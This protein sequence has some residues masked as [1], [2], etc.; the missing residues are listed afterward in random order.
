MNAPA[1]QKPGFGALWKNKM[2]TG[3]QPHYR[4]EVVLRDDYKAGET[5]RI[6]C[7]IKETRQGDKFLSLAENDK[8]YQK[9][10]EDVE[11]TSSYSARRKAS[12]DDDLPF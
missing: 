5:V 1:Q 8:N 11:V 3:S 7:W 4:G 9:V 2:Q 6:S 12:E 10:K